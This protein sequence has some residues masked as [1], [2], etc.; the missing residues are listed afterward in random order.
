IKP[1]MEIGVV[2]CNICDDKVQT[3]IIVNSTDCGLEHQYGPIA[4]SI[5]KAAGPQL[6]E[7]C[8]NKYPEGISE[9]RVAITKGYNLNC[10]NIFH[11]YL[12]NWK[13]DLTLKNLTEIMTK[14][15]QEADQLGAKSI[16]FPVLG[17]GVLK[18]PIEKLPPT[19]YEAA[20]KYFEE[21]NTSR[22]KDVKFVIYPNDTKIIEVFKNYL[23]RPSLVSRVPYTWSP[24]EKDQLL[25]IVEVTSGKEYDDIM[26]IFSQSLPSYR[27][28]CIKRIQNITLY[29][30]YQALKEKYEL[31]NRS[32][33]NEVKNLWHGT[34]NSAVDGINNNGFNRSY[35]G[36]NAV[37]YGQGVYFAKDIRYSA[38][39]KYSAPDSSGIKRI[40][41]C[42]VLV[43]QTIRGDPN[44]KVLEKYNSAV[45]DTNDPSIFVTF[46][47]SQAYPEYLISFSKTLDSTFDSC[48]II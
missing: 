24:M 23:Q 2:V 47:D 34:S 17:A 33:S 6:R 5:L 42:C 32:I 36:K 25:K 45:D 46:H 18:Y 4:K 41:K 14:C 19:M 39:D 44:L 35:C 38:H 48:N 43:G 7:E 27:V 1:E 11:V 9:S 20:R 15:L 29:K 28:T 10:K 31:E 26:N 13:S 22:L 40:Y 37:A 12:P 21:N 30:G 16:A 3:D 8:S